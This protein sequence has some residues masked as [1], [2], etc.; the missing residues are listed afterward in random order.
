MTKRNEK[1]E[2]TG[3]RFLPEC[4]RE[5]AYEH[6]H[7]Y[8]WAVDMIRDKEVLDAACGEGY[9]SDLLARTARSVIGVDVDQTSIEHAKNRYVAPNLEFRQADVRSLPIESSSIDVVVS[10]E[11]IEHVA[12]HD[13]LLV[14][15]KRVLRPDGF[16][17]LS[18][19]DKASYSDQTGYNNPFHVRELYRKELEA[20]LTR[21]FRS[22]QL[23]SQKLTFASTIW[24]LSSNGEGNSNQAVWLTQ[25][26]QGI[27]TGTAPCHV[28]QYFLALAS[29][30]GRMPA[31]PGLSLFSDEAESVYRHYQEEIRHHII[32]GDVLAAKDEEIAK[33]KSQRGQSWWQRLWHQ[34][35][36]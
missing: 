33:L 17:V 29:D 16:L 6:W 26:D 9:G 1:M 8:A 2:F 27:I 10:F 21:H 35:L 7:R 11:T 30:L 18:S 34:F 22:H 24:P 5:M 12:D 31:T 36:G 13:D 25:S 15:F 32:S 28:P 19:P 20:L 3:E 23:F 14:E 4:V